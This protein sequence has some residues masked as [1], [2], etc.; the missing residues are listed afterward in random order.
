MTSWQAAI[1]LSLLIA[2]VSVPAHATLG[3][4]ASTIENDRIR[5]VGRK[6]A[7][8][9][10]GEVTSHEVTLENGTVTRQLTRADGTV[11][12]VSWQGPVRPNLNQLFGTSYFQRF[13]SDN[14]PAGRIRMRRALAST[15]SD[16]VVRT[17]GHA[18]AFWGFAFLPEV[19]P[20]GFSAQSLQAGAQ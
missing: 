9:V 11:F 20:V 10:Q 4:K 1:A 14:A 16:F 18:G 19:A 17:G 7:Q 3:G 8:T 12:A 15:H 6:S 5:M 13:Q 2:S